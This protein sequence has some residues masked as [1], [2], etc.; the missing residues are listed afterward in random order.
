M[1]GGSINSHS[2]LI[3]HHKTYSLNFYIQIPITDRCFRRD[4]GFPGCN[5]I[6]DAE[7]NVDVSSVS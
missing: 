3:M 1:P 7:S 2:L 4:F 5:N 6:Q